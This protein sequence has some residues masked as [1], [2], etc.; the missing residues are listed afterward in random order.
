MVREAAKRQKETVELKIPPDERSLRAEENYQTVVCET[1]KV[2]QEMKDRIRFLENKHIID[3]MKVIRERIYSYNTAGTLQDRFNYYFF[4]TRE[5]INNATKSKVIIEIE[6]WSFLLGMFEMWTENKLSLKETDEEVTDFIKNPIL[7]EFFKKDLLI[8]GESKILTEIIS[9][10]LLVNEQKLLH[11][12]HEEIFGPY[13]RNLYD[14]LFEYSDRQIKELTGLM[15]LLIID[16]LNDVVTFQ[17]RIELNVPLFTIDSEGNVNGGGFEICSTGNTQISFN[18]EMWVGFY[19]K[20]ILAI[21]PS[22]KH[23]RYYCSSPDLIKE[24]LNYC[25]K[26]PEFLDKFPEVK[27]LFKR[28]MEYPAKL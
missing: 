4:C 17:E 5:I 27:A 11:E 8:N 23:K 14:D 7:K 18:R 15:I 13:H 24:I 16:C 26:N 20:Y 10:R 3:R 25:N 6:T 19:P 21:P 28:V 12:K 22:H 9:L 1:H 2:L